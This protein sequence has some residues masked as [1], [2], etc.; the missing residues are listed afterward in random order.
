MPQQESKTFPAQPGRTGAG[1]ETVAS[2]TV[3]PTHRE[4]AAPTIVDATRY[5]LFSVVLIALGLFALAAANRAFSPEMYDAGK[6]ASIGEILGSGTN[7]A[8]FDL[9]V[10]IREIRDAQLRHMKSKPDLVI[11]GASHWQE[12]HSGLAQHKTMFNAHVHRDYYEDILGMV[13]IL[14]RHEKLPRQLLIAIR[15]NQFTPIELRR[16]HL[17]L[18]GVPYYR[19]MANRLEIEQSSRWETLPLARGGDLISVQMLFRNASRWLRA[20]ERPHATSS[21]NFDHLDVLLAD[22]S[23]TWSNR[24][25]AS[26]TATRSRELAQSYVNT[27]RNSPPVIDPKGVAAVHRLLG[28]LTARGVQVVLAHPPFNPITFAGLKEAPYMDGLRRVEKLTRDLAQRH[29]L[30]VIGNFDPAIVGCDEAMFIDSEHANATCLTRIFD[31]LAMLDGGRTA[32]APS[33]APAKGP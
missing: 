12:A 5:V 6:S 8:V 16:D 20:D 27:Q 17:W 24:H 26:F 4:R 22:G 3:D 33:A 9:N 31:Q 19:A 13:E 21:A 18:P 2:A 25:K 30:H 10:N 14:V 15:D 11:L 1:T 32:R 28:F 7:Y 23:I 29:G